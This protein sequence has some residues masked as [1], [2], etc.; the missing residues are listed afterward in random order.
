MEYIYIISARRI[1]PNT[2]DKS[3]CSLMGGKTNLMSRQWRGAYMDLRHGDAGKKR[4]S[5]KASSL[6]CP[7]VQLFYHW[8]VRVPINIQQADCQLL[9]KCLP[10]A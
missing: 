1:W 2:T 10:D 6:S 4:W 5:Y 9:Y 3:V 7:L 8:T